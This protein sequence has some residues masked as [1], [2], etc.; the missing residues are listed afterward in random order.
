[1]KLDSTDVGV[2]ELVAVREIAAAFLTSEDASDVFQLA[3]DRVSPIVGSSF[4]CIY[5]VDGSSDL[6]RLG[7]VHN[8]PARYA[9]FL[10]E[11]RVRLGAGP[12]GRAASERRVIEI[13]DVFADASVDDWRE[14][15]NELGFRSLVALPLETPGGVLGTVTFYFTGSGALSSDARGLLQLVADQMAATV[16]KARLIEDLKATNAALQGTNAE[17]EKQYAALVEARR[18]QDEFLSNVSHELRTPLTAVLGYL[19]LMEEGLGGPVTDEQAVTI[20][21]MKGSSEKLLDLI[22]DLL[23]LT[24]LKRNEISLQVTDFDP[25][26]PLRMALAATEGKAGTVSL[27]VNESHDLPRMR[28]DSRK[29]SR[30]ISTL[31]RNAYKFTEKGEVRVAVRAQGDRI[32]YRISDTGVGISEAAQRFVFDEFR[33][34]DGSATRKYGGSGLGLAIARRLARLLGGEITLSSERGKGS[35]FE[36]ELPLISPR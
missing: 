27:V 20:T 18:L 7:A 11:M 30:L 3:L 32:L 34:E 12:S 25:A 24:A 13:P 5:L 15:A 16:E 17:L 19:S 21:Q 1:M 8:W 31:L 23:E 9:R 6:M 28:G 36:V 10:G 2:R 14:V 26:E 35:T 29:T 4:S 22:T 33:Q